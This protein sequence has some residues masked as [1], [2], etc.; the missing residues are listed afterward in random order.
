MYKYDVVQY[1]N[2]ICVY[3]IHMHTCTCYVEMN[4]ICKL[5]YTSDLVDLLI[6][7]ASRVVSAFL[8]NPD[9]PPPPL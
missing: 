6:D 3:D 4:I 1:S 7:F 5:N 8:S 2:I 9:I